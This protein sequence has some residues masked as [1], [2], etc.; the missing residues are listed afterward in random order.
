MAGTQWA[1]FSDALLPVTAGAFL[2]IAGSDLIPELNRRHSYPASKSVGQLLMMV[3]G[4]A[5]MALPLLLGD[6]H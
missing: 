2:Y 4:V 5:V 1:G 3:L 6:A